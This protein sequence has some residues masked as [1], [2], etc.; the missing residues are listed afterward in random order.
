M[1]HAA[2][3]ALM[4]WM[5]RVWKLRVLAHVFERVVLGRKR[6]SSLTSKQGY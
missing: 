2:L 3:A 4:V 6:S 1:P 5:L